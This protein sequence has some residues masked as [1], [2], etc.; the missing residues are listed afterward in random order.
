MTLIA[1]LIALAI[2]RF[3]GV[4]DHLRGFGWF[5]TST[6][7]LLHKAGQSGFIAGPL[8]VVL[9]LLLPVALLA[10][11]S[12]LL[13][14]YSIVLNFV[15]ATVVLLLCLGPV[16]L[17]QQLEQY[18]H[19]LQED[20]PAVAEAALNGF[21]DRQ[22][23]PP[24]L[25]GILASLFEQSNVRLFSVL[26]WFVVLGPV[27]ALLYRLTA[28][29]HQ[30]DLTEHDSDEKQTPASDAR[31]FAA[32]A[33]DLYDLLNWPGSRLLALAHALAGSLVEALDDWRSAEAANVRVNEA[34]IRESGLGALQFRN[35]YGDENRSGEE[36]L[37]EE[38]SDDDIIS[39]LDAAHAL[40]QRALIVWLSVLGI[41]TIAGWLG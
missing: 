27:G 12:L 3:I 24:G 17:R 7:W 14:E 20:D 25:A 32:A 39:W 1:I 18:Q 33:H 28:E 6:H 8:G 36:G 16:D 29:L 2:E 37:P 22:R 19:A 26:F 4:V 31:N 40:Q 9:A 10:V 15:L 30:L 35:I 23:Q 38:L 21:H 41:M 34:V 11:V 13:H 5:H